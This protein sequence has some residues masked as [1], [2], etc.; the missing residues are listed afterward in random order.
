VVDAKAVG[1]EVSR[2]R[3][4]VAFVALASKPLGVLRV[5]VKRALTSVIAGLE[6][7]PDVRAVVL[8]GKG[9]AFSVGADVKEFR[10]D[11][12]WLCESE[13]EENR[14]HDAIESARFPVIA[15]C[16]GYTLGG[17]LVL[18]LACDIRV[19]A[20]SATFGVPEVKVGAFAS[21]SGT[22]RL[23]RH[24][25]RGRALYLMLTAQMV[26]AD[27]ARS[28]GLVEEVVADEELHPRA[29]QLAVE[30]ASRPAAAVTACKRCVA[31]GVRQGWAEAMALEA[32]LAVDVGLSEDA[33]EAQRA[34]MEKRPP[35]F[36]R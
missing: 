25:G 22:Q 10:Q 5:V 8:T 35:R 14:M 6:S 30:I 26:S 7:D 2:P 18:A 31:A 29:L 4:G 36:S 28:L 20:K 33:A 11:T 19:A 23:L 1:V 13:F 15:A 27:E 34:F 17:G 3:P 16:N 12:G 24:A 9:K 21:A 32:R